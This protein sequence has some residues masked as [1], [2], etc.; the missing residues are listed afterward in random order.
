[1]TLMQN[2]LSEQTKINAVLSYFLLGP[3]F[4]LAHSNP[5]LAHPFVRSHAKNASK[6]LIIGAILW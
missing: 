5:N 4:L 3:I 6:I 1:M 2:E